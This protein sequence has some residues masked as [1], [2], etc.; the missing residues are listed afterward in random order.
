MNEKPQLPIPEPLTGQEAGSWA[1][2]TI[3]VRLP[4]IARRIL[5]ENDFPPQVRTAI[6][7]LIEELPFGRIRKLNDPGSPDL[8]AWDGYIA[9][10]EGADWLEIAWF[11]AEVYFYRRV[12]EASGYFQP[13]PTYRID[14][15]GYQKSTGLHNSQTDLADLLERQSPWLAN[16]NPEG[17]RNAFQAAL[18][19]NQ[20]D[21][22]I[23]P[24]EATEDERT[25]LRPSQANM[26]VDQSAAV[27]DLLNEASG[28]FQRVDLILDNAA[29]EL[30]ADLAMID[31]LLTGRIST[32]VV[33]HAKAH[34]TFV[35]DV[36]RSDLGH[37]LAYLQGHSNEKLQTLGNRLA[38]QLE[39]GNIEIKDHFY[40]NS[41]LSG[42]EMP[43]D[44]RQDLAKSDLVI[45]KGDANY[46]RLLGDR[47]WPFTT[48]FKNIVTYLPMP[49]LALRTLKSEIATDLQVGQEGEL[50]QLDPDWLI[51]GRWGVMQFAP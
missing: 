33:L 45:S 30:L 35:S 26:L 31:L 32:K 2:S 50:D 4:E 42:W 19:G 39:A 34:P 43:P 49:L 6:R 17:L 44:L 29:F 36:I 38:R 46:R 41:P 40:W 12:L 13:G 3:K 8:K 37:T 15:F 11:F 14:P 1:E 28:R 47:N 51:S 5:A 9:R 48:P 21:L 7:M 18:W 10:Y 20:V 16:P 23:W 25:T 22:S 24:A 27:F